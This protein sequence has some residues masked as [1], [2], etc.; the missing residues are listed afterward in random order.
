MRHFI[1]S[2]TAV[3][4]GNPSRVPVR[5]DDPTVPISP[6]GSSKLMTEIMLRDAGNA[7]GLRHLILRYFNVAG[8]DPLGRTGQSTRGATHLIKIAGET[9]LGLRP[10]MHVFGTDYPTPDGTCIRDSNHVSD[11]VAAYREERLPPTVPLCARPGYLFDSHG[12]YLLDD[13][14]GRQHRLP[15]SALRTSI[16]LLPRRL[17]MSSVRASST[18]TS[19]GRSSFGEQS[20]PY[21][22]WRESEKAKAAI[23][24]RSSALT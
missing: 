24:A 8:A 10:N 15:G 14:G 3:V 18:S 20:R 17:G 22:R 5:E 6:Y 19:P 9:A 2:S 7:H 12:G 13:R 1:F 11:L 4:Y 21:F 23:N 16:R